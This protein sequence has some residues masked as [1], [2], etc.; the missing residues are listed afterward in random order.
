MLNWCKSWNTISYLIITSLM[1]TKTLNLEKFD[2]TKVI[3][4]NTLY[5]DYFIEAFTIVVNII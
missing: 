4:L 5:D 2:Y 1:S 3:T